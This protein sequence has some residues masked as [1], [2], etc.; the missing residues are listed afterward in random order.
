MNAFKFQKRFLIGAGECVSL[1][2]LY[3][4][5]LFI[6]AKI[7]LEE[8]FLM[9][10]PLHS[11]NF[12]TEAE[13][14]IT[15]NRRIVTK[16]MWYNESEISTKARRAIENEEVNI[17][18]HISG[19]IHSQFQEATIN[20]YDYRKFSD[21]LQKFLK[22]DDKEKEFL[23]IDAKLPAENK[24][25][26]ETIAL[27]INVDMSRDDIERE[28]ILKS[29]ENEVA[30]LAIYASRKMN[31]V[32]WQPFLKAAFERNPVCIVALKDKEISEIYEI[33]KQMPENS[34]YE[35]ENRVALP[36]EVWNF[37]RGDGLEK[38]LLFINILKNR[39]IEVKNISL[40]NNTI[41]IIANNNAFHFQ[42]EKNILLKN[43]TKNLAI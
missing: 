5:A 9:A 25:Q 19:Y 6:V 12:I 35:E 22:S 11:Q 2:T 41:S 3:A 29:E 1:S 15:N 33:L 4:A 23:N 7:P 43:F 16:N 17:V 38:C 42:S 34:I 32:D 36:D 21:K 37:G 13:G 31:I 8:I 18:S 10:T 20:F 14:F 30:K 24:E 26:I 40:L 39:K 27:N 28:I